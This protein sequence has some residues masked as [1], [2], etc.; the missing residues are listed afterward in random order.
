MS[1]LANTY[2]V[3]RN[4]VGF[5]CDSLRVKVLRDMGDTVIVITADL[6]DAGTKLALDKSQVE[7]E[8]TSEVFFHKTG[9]VAF[10]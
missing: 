2:A 10:A 4:L 7:V 1:S 6:C 3:A 5:S 9:L 8:K